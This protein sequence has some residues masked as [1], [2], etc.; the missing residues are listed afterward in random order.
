MPKYGNR[1]PTEGKQKN[2][3]TRPALKKAGDSFDEEVKGDSSPYP[4][5]VNLKVSPKGAHHHRRTSN[6]NRSAPVLNVD[7]VDDAEEQPF[8][9]SFQS[10]I[11]SNV[12]K[13]R[14]Q[15][16]EEDWEE[17]KEERKEARGQEDP[18]EEDEQA[19]E[20]L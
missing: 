17:S 15:A 7:D 14:E 4:D 16:V 11:P 19:E 6:P 8:R 12:Q 13:K 5:N 9:S 2:I 20:V 18:M 3:Q 1:R 10:H